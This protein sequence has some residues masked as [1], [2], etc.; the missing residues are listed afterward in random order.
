MTNQ[1]ATVESIKQGLKTIYGDAIIFK[2]YFDKTE[3]ST[4]AIKINIK[5]IG[6]Q[7]GSRVIYYQTVH[8][9]IIAASSAAVTSWGSAVSSVIISQP[10]YQDNFVAQGWWMGAAYL[11]I[12]LV[13]N[14]NNNKK[15]I[16]FPFVGEDKQ[17]NTWGYK[18]G[19]I[20][21]QNAWNKTSAH[22]LDLIDSVIMKTIEYQK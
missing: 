2:S 1:E 15:I 13:D 3:D 11:D 17:N 7:F 10:I 19:S 16:D 21:A 14:L 6:S 22:L 20:A 5:E 9:Q 8:N 18:S 4:V 12:S